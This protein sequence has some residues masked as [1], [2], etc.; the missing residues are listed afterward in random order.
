MGDIGWFL[1]IFVVF[2]VSICFLFSLIDKW[3]EPKDSYDKWLEAELKRNPGY[4]NWL[5]RA[6]SGK[7]YKR[8]LRI[9][10]KIK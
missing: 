3:T 4:I 5:K 9:L 7:D 6:N 2:L 10:R 8:G 1:P